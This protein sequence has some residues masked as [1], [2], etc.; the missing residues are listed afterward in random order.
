MEWLKVL[1]KYEI[2]TF[3]LVRGHQKD[4]FKEAGKISR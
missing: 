2:E 3:N 4:L 1:L